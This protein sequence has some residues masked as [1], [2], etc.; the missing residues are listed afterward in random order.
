MIRI[1][2]FYDTA[3]G[4]IV[5]FTKLKD[6]SELFA[7]V[8]PNTFDDKMQPNV[9]FYI[10]KDQEWVLVSKFDSSEVFPLKL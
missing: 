8:Y 9:L 1:K 7:I 4:Q 10:L 5:A 6:N 3:N 2:E